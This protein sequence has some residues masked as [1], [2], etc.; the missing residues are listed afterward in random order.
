MSYS[1]PSLKSLPDDKA[2]WLSKFMANCYPGRADSDDD[3][4]YSCHYMGVLAY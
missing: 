3:T 1:K 4:S 2:R